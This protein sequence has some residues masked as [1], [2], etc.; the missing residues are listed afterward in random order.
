M[1]QDLASDGGLA[2]HRQQGSPALEQCQELDE[3]PLGYIEIALTGYRVQPV[4]ILKVRLPRKVRAAQYAELSVGNP[5]W[6]ANDEDGLS[7]IA[8]EGDPI[9]MEETLSN[10]SHLF[11]VGTVSKRCYDFV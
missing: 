3:H 2:E 1:R 4:V 9:G 11:G 5:R 6:V 8:E 7:K 10:H